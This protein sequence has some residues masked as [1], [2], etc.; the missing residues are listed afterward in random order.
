LAIFIPVVFMQGI[1]G[2]FFYQ[3]GVTM[4]VAV[5]ISLLEALT[6]APMRCS[7]F[8]TTS[9]ENRITRWV[10]HQMNRLADAY[11][12][13]LSWSLERRWTVIICSVL[14]FALSLLTIK[15]LRQEFVPPQDQS[16]F[17]V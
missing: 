4:S 6:L 13:G 3:F 17:L 2:K 16:R 15:G 8:M 12:Q 11:R 5:L 10:S 1:I 14:I 9:K 7:Q